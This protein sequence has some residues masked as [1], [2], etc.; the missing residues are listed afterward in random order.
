MKRFLLF[1]YADY[2]GSGGMHDFKDSFGS[3]YELIKF[4]IL[5]LAFDPY[6]FPENYQIVDTQNN[7]S[8][9]SYQTTSIRSDHE[10]IVQAIKKD[11]ELMHLL[12]KTHK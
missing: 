8:Y 6:A 7:L 10:A 5:E 11:L 12:H 3:T 4:M 1:T 2:E 9:K